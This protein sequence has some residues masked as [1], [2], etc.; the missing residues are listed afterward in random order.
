M[1]YIDG[2]IATKLQQL[3]ECAVDFFGTAD[4]D[5]KFRQ[6]MADIQAKLS[7]FTFAQIGSLYQDEQTKEFYIGPELETGKGPW[8]SPLEYFSDLTNHALQ[9]CLSSNNS[10]TQ[11]VQEGFSFTLPIVFRH[12]ISLYGCKDPT[13]GPFRLTNRDFGAHNLLVNDE[14]E[15]IGVIDL[16]GVMAAPIEVVAQ[17]PIFSGLEREAPGHVETRPL[18]IER[19]K[20][21][22]PRL[23][24]YKDLLK[25]SEDQVKEGYEGDGGVADYLLS[26]SSSIFQ[27]LKGYG[28]QKS[29][30]DKWMTAYIKLL[31]KKLRSGEP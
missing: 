27:G 16:D 10:E 25:K 15:V 20:R 8:N 11:E 24:E 9:A 6:Q 31:Q 14:F 3:K 18:A 5:R 23:E 1:D 21:T 7:S 2:T 19:I 29:R 13:S 17:Y 4:Q 22:K 12:L 30:H 28:L 26:D